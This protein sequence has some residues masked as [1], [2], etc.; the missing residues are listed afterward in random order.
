MYYLEIIASC[1]LE[2]GLHSKLNDCMIISNQDRGQGS[3]CLF[4]Q[5]L[6]VLC[7]N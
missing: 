5:V 6:Y 4:N 2:C 7:L 1:D 3:L